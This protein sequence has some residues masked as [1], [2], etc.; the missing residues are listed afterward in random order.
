M[1][2]L[3]S[4]LMLYIYLGYKEWFHSLMWSNINESLRIVSSGLVFY[5]VV[6]MLQEEDCHFNKVL[7]TS[8]VILTI[9]TLYK[10]N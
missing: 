6:L 1:L 2:Y 10:L 7:F 3:P 5:T 8:I 9:T 4:I